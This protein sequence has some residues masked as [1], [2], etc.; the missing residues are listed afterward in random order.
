M[1]VLL[2]I[3]LLSLALTVFLYT[4]YRRDASSKEGNRKIHEL[5]TISLIASTMWLF[6]ITLW[7]IIY[8]IN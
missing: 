8:T 2:F 1:F 6:V 5:N 3:W 7:F 4:T